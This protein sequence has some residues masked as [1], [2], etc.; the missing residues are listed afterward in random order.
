MSLLLDTI[1]Q[2]SDVE[3]WYN[4]VKFKMSLLLDGIQQASGIEIC[5]KIAI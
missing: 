2:A 5:W 1:Q 3:I 4:I